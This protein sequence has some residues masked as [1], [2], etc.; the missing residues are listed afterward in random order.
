MNKLD[1]EHL[2]HKIV[3]IF[4]DILPDIIGRHTKGYQNSIKELE[5][6]IKEKNQS[7]QAQVSSRDITIK[8]LRLIIENKT[9]VIQDLQ[10]HDSIDDSIIIGNLRDQLELE[11]T[12]VVRLRGAVDIWQGK[13]NDSEKELKDK[14]I[15]RVP[16]NT[17][18]ETTITLKNYQIRIRNLENKNK[19]LTEELD[20]CE[21]G[22]D[23]GKLESIKWKDRTIEF[24]ETTI[25]GLREVVKTQDAT[26]RA[27]DKEIIELKNHPNWKILNAQKDKLNE[28]RNQTGVMMTIINEVETLT[29]KE[30]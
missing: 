5:E 13:Y 27:E 26:I 23:S 21:S 22:V 10:K 17:F 3:E 4:E 11:S 6:I 18:N 30:D 8:D 25:S 2:T 28:L 1:A 7:L 29:N 19:E 9:K 12:E 20:H 24:L 15:V 14:D 16:I